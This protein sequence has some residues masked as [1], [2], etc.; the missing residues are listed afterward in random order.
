MDYEFDFETELPEDMLEL[1]LGLGKDMGIDPI[2]SDAM[3][4]YFF[5]LWKQF[6]GDK[7]ER[8]GY[9]ERAIKRDFKVM[10]EY[11]HWLQETEWQFHNGKPMIFVGQLDATIRRDGGLYGV[12]FYVFWDEKDGTTKTVTQ[13]D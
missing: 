3:E 5:T 11:P 12:S 8:Q 6:S 1:L 2:S 9:F 7:R 10:K 4:S 13:C